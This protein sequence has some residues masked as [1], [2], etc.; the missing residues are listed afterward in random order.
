MRSQ[1]YVLN[2]IT[3]K[4]PEI[5]VIGNTFDK[6][7]RQRY[8]EN[9]VMLP[10]LFAFERVTAPI[11]P[12]I[13]Q[14]MYATWSTIITHVV[15]VVIDKDQGRHDDYKQDLYVEA[16]KYDPL[17]CNSYIQD[18]TVDLLTPCYFME[19]IHTNTSNPRVVRTNYARSLYTA[20]VFGIGMK[21]I[22]SAEDDTW[23]SQYIYSKSIVTIL[24]LSS[25]PYSS[26]Y[27]SN[28]QIVR[29]SAYRLQ[30]VCDSLIAAEV[31][32]GISNV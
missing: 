19:N 31:D 17:M 8:M 1:N 11:D 30:V 14:P 28:L 7:I 4:L 5:G 23:K 18:D 32:L 15:D 13:V 3:E 12:A 22:L 2:A 16:K 25:V 20:D 6:T 10:I 9:N 24:L 27:S 26:K 29:P 21:Q